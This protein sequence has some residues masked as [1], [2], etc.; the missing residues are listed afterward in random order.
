MNKIICE[1]SNL[2]IHVVASAGDESG[3]ACKKSPASAPE[4]ITVGATEKST[5]DITK[6]TNFGDCVDIFAPGR[7]IIAAGIGLNTP[8]SK[9]SGTSQ[10]CPH[11]TGA[12]A[13]II[14]KKGNLKPSSMA[15]EL[16]LLSVKNILKPINVKPNRF[17][18]VPRP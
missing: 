3:N 10:A 11:V 15:N 2:G 1:C 13:L 14:S 18:N 16:I 6:S 12:I 4:A 9:A 5:D 8:L 7:D 17:L